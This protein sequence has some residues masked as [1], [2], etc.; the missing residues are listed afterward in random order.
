MSHL[1][2]TGRV[3][4]TNDNYVFMVDNYRRI[5]I[6]YHDGT[7][8]FSVDDRVTCSTDDF[9]ISSWYSYPHAIVARVNNLRK[10]Q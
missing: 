6:A 8:E 10:I 4:S 1:V 9:D 2:F 7:H 5:M 3:I